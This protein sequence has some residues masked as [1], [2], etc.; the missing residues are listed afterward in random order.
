MIVCILYVKE[1]RTNINIIYAVKKDIE[2]NLKLDTEPYIEAEFEETNNLYT[3]V[4]TQQKISLL[5]LINWESELFNKEGLSLHCKLA[6]VPCQ[7]IKFDTLL[8]VMDHL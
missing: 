8:Q 7:Q 5:T 2:L 4:L 3:V 6:G 1:M